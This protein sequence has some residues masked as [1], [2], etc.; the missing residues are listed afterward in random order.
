MQAIQSLTELVT[1]DRHF[2]ERVWFLMLPNQLREKNCFFNNCDSSLKHYIN[3]APWKGQNCHWVLAKI[4]ECASM[5]GRRH[6]GSQY[7]PYFL[8][9]VSSHSHSAHTQILNHNINWKDVKKSLNKC[10]ILGRVLGYFFKRQKINSQIRI[11]LKYFLFKLL[12]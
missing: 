4:D 7:L 11:F 2:Q 1:K 6:Y 10:K 5:W 9:W 12:K 8:H 3:L